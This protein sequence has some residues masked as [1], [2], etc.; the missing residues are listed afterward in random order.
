[1]RPNNSL[2]AKLN[3]MRSRANAQR[4][5]FKN[6][7]FL[8]WLNAPPRIQKTNSTNSLNTTASGNSSPKSVNSTKTNNS[9]VS[10]GSYNRSA[11]ARAAEE[12]ETAR[13][14]KQEQIAATLA[15]AKSGSPTGKAN[16]SWIKKP[17]A[18]AS[19]RGGRRC[20]SRR[21]R[22]QRRRR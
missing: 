20:W 18:P 9:V 21:N 5:T 1:M 7:S 8:A 10:W 22:T 3:R 15:R 2:Q 16:T 17:V 14:E 19:R 6:N 12:E 11:W 13:R 4:K